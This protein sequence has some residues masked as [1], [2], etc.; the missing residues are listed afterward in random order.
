M[1]QK[2]QCS[3]RITQTTKEPKTIFLP[4]SEGDIKT[5]ALRMHG[6]YEVGGYLISSFVSS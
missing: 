2:L 6:S 5:H 3:Q 4:E 1:I